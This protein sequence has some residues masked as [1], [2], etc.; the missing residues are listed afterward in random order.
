[1]TRG[2]YRL[3]SAGAR[4]SGYL[5]GVAEFAEA[6]R[7]L[8]EGQIHGMRAIATELSQAIDTVASEIRR[9]EE[10]DAGLREEI[11]ALGVTVLS[12]TKSRAERDDEVRA[13]EREAIAS[14]FDQE[15]DLAI[16]RAIRAGNRAPDHPPE[17]GR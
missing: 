11:R 12:L 2:V 15:G 3:I 5:G 6:E 1:M 16:A 17:Q 9:V 14:Y 10:G 13:E 4:A 8:S 7:P